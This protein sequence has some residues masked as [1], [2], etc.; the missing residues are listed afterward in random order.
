MDSKPAISKGPA[1]GLSLETNPPKEP[2]GVKD[3]G[4]LLQARCR[5]QALIDT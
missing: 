3:S 5:V 2:A 1:K 4:F